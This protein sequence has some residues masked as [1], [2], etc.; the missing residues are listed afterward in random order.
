MPASVRLHRAQSLCDA[1]AYVRVRACSANLAGRTRE[2]TR[3]SFR[4]IIMADDCAI[5]FGLAMGYGPRIFI[6]GT[7]G[8]RQKDLHRLAADQVAMRVKCWYLNALAVNKKIISGSTLRCTSRWTARRAIGEYCLT[9]G[10][11]ARFVCVH[12]R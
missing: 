4:N 2:S 1:R 5:A 10:F 7:A 11:D 9:Q 12:G 6:Y 3:Q 8:K